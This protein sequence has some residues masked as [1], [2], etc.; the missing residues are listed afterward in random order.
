MTDTNWEDFDCPLL[1]SLLDMGNGP[2]QESLSTS[3]F[4]QTRL[5]NNANFVDPFITANNSKLDTDLDNTKSVEFGLSC[6]ASSSSS[7]FMHPDL[8]SRQ[9][10]QSRLSNLSSGLAAD[11][12]SSLDS[13]PANDSNPE[14]GSELMLSE[15]GMWP[16]EKI[17]SLVGSIFPFGPSANSIEPLSAFNMAGL[18]QQIHQQLNQNQQSQPSS[19]YTEG[20]ALGQ[21]DGVQT[22][23]FQQ[24]F[25]SYVLPQRTN[26]TNETSSNIGTPHR[27]YIS[28]MEEAESS[29]AL[30]PFAEI[31]E[32]AG[33]ADSDTPEFKKRRKVA[34]ACVHCKK[35]HVSCEVSRP[36]RRCIKKGMSDS[37]VDAPRKIVP[38]P[39]VTR[40]CRTC[41]IKILPM[42][43]I[44]GSNVGSTLQ[45]PSKLSTTIGSSTCVSSHA[46]PSSSSTHTREPE[47]KL[48]RLAIKRLGSTPITHPPL[49]AGQHSST[50]AHTRTYNHHV[51]PP[52]IN[53]SLQRQLSQSRRLATHEQQLPLSTES[54]HNNQPDL[55][56]Q[57]SP[58]LAPDANSLNLLQ[59]LVNAN[60]N[61]QRWTLT[62]QLITAIQSHLSMLNMAVNTD[63][64]PNKSGSLVNHCKE[65]NPLKRCTSCAHGLACSDLVKEEA[66]KK[67]DGAQDTITIH[68][69]R[70]SAL[71]LG[72]PQVKTDSSVSNALAS[73]GSTP[74]LK[75][76]HSTPGT[77][78]A[79]Q[80]TTNQS[81]ITPNFHS[82]APLEA[83]FTVQNIEVGVSS[84]ILFL[85]QQL[86]QSKP[87]RAGVHPALLNSQQVHVND[88]LMLLSKAIPA[89]PSAVFSSSGI[90]FTCNAA[91]ARLVQLDISVLVSGRFCIFSLVDMPSMLNVLDLALSFALKKEAQSFGRCSVFAGGNTGTNPHQANQGQSHNGQR[92]WVRQCALAIST[93]HDSGLWIVAQFIPMM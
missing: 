43:N 89:T 60:S 74:D 40:S 17:A 15:D 27:D 30:S 47:A 62:P 92:T 35:A 1:D 58:A 6:V 5:S 93:L 18:Q 67:S 75:Y 3:D 38:V 64:N 68:N 26:S 12:A 10:G 39:S 56:G 2:G 7:A 28:A 25:E 55:N 81:N 69:R 72:S 23:D 16:I 49:S 85:V 83:A 41:P 61:D 91:F 44:T 79:L 9:S 82:T 32:A 50:S 31:E 8:I 63:L 11:F 87:V 20:V 86:S 76:G 34:Q 42:Q 29:M 70:V 37:C 78:T 57:Q 73:P 53:I 36:C 13:R 80:L 24:D 71:S 46:I 84:H 65:T 19:I 48:S 14:I 4:I 59:E 90:I 21:F 54:N 88:Y 51:M 66:N 52:E 22:R 45:P 33:R 77:L